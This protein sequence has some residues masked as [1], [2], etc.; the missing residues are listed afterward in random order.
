MSRKYGWAEELY[1]TIARI[2]VALTNFHVGLNPLRLQDGTWYRKYEDRLGEVGVGRKNK[3]N[4]QQ[5]ESRARRKRRLQY[6]S[7]SVPDSSDT[8][9]ASP[10]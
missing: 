10:S 5:A 1:D 2:C 4:R 3:R 7:R 9:T 8:D 6:G